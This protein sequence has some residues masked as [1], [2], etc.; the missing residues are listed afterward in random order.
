M[1]SI[2]SERKIRLTKF[3][4]MKNGGSRDEDEDEFPSTVCARIKCEKQISRRD[5]RS[6]LV[7]QLRSNNKTNEDELNSTYLIKDE[8]KMSHRRQ[9]LEMWRQ[10]R[11]EKMI[12]SKICQRPVFKVCH[13]NI[14][15]YD[16][17]NVSILGANTSCLQ[18]ATSFRSIYD[19]RGVS[20]LPSSFSTSNILIF[21]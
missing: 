21:T 18:R 10:E 1:N 8:P 14:K 4:P 19:T 3:R 5:R 20:N 7:D 9:L 16:L 12:S 17:S 13:L 11:K 2:A 15:D 6:K